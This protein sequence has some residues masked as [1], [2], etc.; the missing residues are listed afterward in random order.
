MFS[1]SPAK[2]EFLL[3]PY[4]GMAFNSSGE[5]GGGEVG[6]SG[7]TVGARLGF[8]KAG[9]SIG[10]DGRRNSWTLDPDS[11]ADDSNVTFTQLGL[12]IGYELPMKVRFW[13]VYIFNMEGVD[14]DNTELVYKE[15][16]GMVFGFGL[17][18]LAWLS[19]NFEVSNLSTAKYDNG[20]TE[21]DLDA[22]YTAYT[23]SISLPLTI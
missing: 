20:T 1:I 10:A 11:G 21:V 12:F 19:A 15:G 4:A 22:D 7:T 18:L 6:I 17:K 14:D 13:G 5:I 3:D 8:Y 2:A 23:L 9:F 16:S